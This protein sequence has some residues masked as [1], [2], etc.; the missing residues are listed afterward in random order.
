MT[1]YDDR[2][3]CA[4]NMYLPNCTYY[5]SA[6]DFS[7]VTPFLPQT[8]TCQIN[9]PY[10]PNIAQVQPFREL[11]FRDYGLDHP[12]KWHYRGNYASYYSTEEIMQRDLIQSSGRADM[13]FKNDSYGHH[14]GANSTCNFLANVGRNGVLPQGFDQFFETLNSEK[15]NPEHIKQKTDSPVPV[16][17]TN[18]GETINTPEQSKAESTEN[19]NE[20]SSLESGDKSSDQSSAKSRKKRCPYSKYQIR[21]LEREFFFNVYINK[22]K[23][24]QLSR[25]LN[26]SDRQVKIW[27]QNRRMKEKKLNRDRLHTPA[28]NHFLVD[29][30][31]G[32]C[33]TDSFYSN[34]GVY[35]SS[36]ADM[37]T[38]GMQ[39]CGLLPSFGKRGEVN[40]QNMGMNV[41]SYTP[42]L[43]NW[44]DPNRSCRLE[45][46]I[47]QMSSVTF[48]QSIKAESNCCM[49]SDNKRAKDSYSE[50]PTYS[51]LVPES[52]AVDSPEIPVP[53]YFRLSQTYASRKH[54]S[55]CHEPPSPNTTTT[56]TLM[57][58]NQV[59]AP[60]TH[61]SYSEV[62]DKASECSPQNREASRTPEP[63]ESPDA[64]SCAEEKRESYVSSSPESSQ[65]ESKEFNK[66][67]PTSNW[68]TAKSGR[69]K[70]CPYTKHQTLELEKEFLFN[71]Y[72]TR[73]RR[74]E[75]SKC[76]NL[77]DRQVK[78]W[79]QN[80]RMK[81]KKMSRENRV[82]ELTSN[83]TFSTLGNC[84]VE[85]IMGHD[86]EDVFGAARFIQG[87]QHT[88]TSRPPGTGDHG[89]F[90]SCHFAPKSAVFP[91]SW[92][93]HSH[94]G[95][96]HPYAHQ[97]H[98]SA[99][100]N[101][102]Y[103]RSWMDPPG[104]SNHAAFSGDFH[105]SSRTYGG[106]KPESV[107]AKSSGRAEC[108]APFGSREPRPVVAEDFACGV[109]ESN[110]KSP[111]ENIGSDLSSH[112]EPKEEKQQLDPNN[113][114]AN[115]IHA[116]STRKKRCARTTKYSDFRVGKEFLYNMYLT[117]DR[118]YEVARILSLTERQVK[119]WFQ[120]RRMK[121]KKM[122]RER[123]SKEHL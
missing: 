53:G 83:L 30:L 47:S 120:N 117:R 17:A 49:Y 98:L 112:S 4:S 118:R 106:A 116:R 108:G 97:A 11:A 58:L 81:L 92:P 55:Y 119:I 2:S 63:V 91:S 18:S 32:A 87:P 121:M 109:S 57:Q 86:A 50:V 103:V 78:I 80:R 7:S 77:S 79:F 1:E 43:D 19:L 3:N 28:A 71:I 38:Y 74:L 51:N 37:G 100:D 21:E 22:E 93:S 113:P 9:F 27:F 68:L 13:L 110:E 60:K 89:D 41:H 35:M 73:E 88:V 65:T 40:H 34:S 114:A 24:L 61:A 16:E 52:C 70:R 10:S 31:I 45:P 6:P 94:P 20:D 15:T 85:S 107:P 104:I 39:T 105:S 56:T 5:V 75:I 84:Y 115:W 99:A 23:R 54:Q 122:N 36:G 76:V 14:F 48:P 46:N 72:L 25:M 8:T 26:L 90:S 111:K 101:S 123:N 69:K 59:V 95:I 64:K 66:D 102:R 96:Y 62:V 33:R 29:S 82:R 12:S 44:T 67:A 42:Q